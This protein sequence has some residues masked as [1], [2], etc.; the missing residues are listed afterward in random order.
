MDFIDP[1]HTTCVYIT[2][3]SRGV[4]A[5]NRGDVGGGGGPPGNGGRGM[6]NLVMNTLG[7]NWAQILNTKP[8]VWGMIK[9]SYNVC[10]GGGCVEFGYMIWQHRERICK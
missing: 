5:T 6:C 3:N 1:G 4:T 7:A 10:K 8:D 2:D 9:S